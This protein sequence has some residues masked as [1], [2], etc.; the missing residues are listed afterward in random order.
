MKTGSNAM[1]EGGGG[2]K[3]WRMVFHERPSKLEVEI[4]VAVDDSA[5][6]AVDSRKQ[7]K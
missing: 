6:I 4:S 1:G 7:R 5:A 3:F 2:G